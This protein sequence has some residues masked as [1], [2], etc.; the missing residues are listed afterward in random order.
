MM[1]SLTAVIISPS[2]AVCL[3]QVSRC[4]AFL[5]TVQY[6]ALCLQC[7]SQAWPDYSRV[8]PRLTNNVPGLHLSFHKIGHLSPKSFLLP[9]IWCGHYIVSYLLV[10]EQNYLE[11]FEVRT[12]P[13][14]TFCA[15]KIN[16]GSRVPGDD[17]HLPSLS[18][19][20]GVDPERRCVR[21]RT[22]ATGPERLIYNGIQLVNYPCT[23]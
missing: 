6:P 1:S 8:R 2:H 10:I 22:S 11:T 4:C 12:T 20:P 21:V 16:Q 9:W 15:P 14:V 18:T 5:Q 7:P 3:F 17:L 23:H 13:T 19:Q